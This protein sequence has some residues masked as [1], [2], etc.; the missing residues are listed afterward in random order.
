MFFI[1]KTFEIKEFRGGE[2]IYKDSAFYRALFVPSKGRIFYFFSFSDIN[3][4]NHL[5]TTTCPS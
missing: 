5:I 4:F 3:K 1:G 2:I